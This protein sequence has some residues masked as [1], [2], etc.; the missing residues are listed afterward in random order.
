VLVV[1]TD[2]PYPPFEFGNPPY[3]GFEVDVVN[4]VARRLGTR[5][6]FE[7]ASFDTI[8]T[9]LAKR[10]FDLVAA[11]TTVSSERHAGTE[12]STPY[13]D[14][15][16]AVV[17]KRGSRIDTEDDLSGKVVGVQLATTG[18]RI[19]KD[20]T[21]ARAIRSFELIDDAFNAL[22]AGQ[23]DAIV[24]DFV[25]SSYA[26]R[27]RP[28]LRV[29]DSLATG[30]QYGIALA[31]GSSLKPKVDGAIARIRE[32]GTYARIYRKWFRSDPP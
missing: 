20:R 31:A 28:E 17:V 5:T 6:R 3:R 15:D 16:Q 7:D 19:A 2:V 9:D 25:V 14:A 1:G 32:D 22:E 13:G 24:N 23:V 29:V 12:Y 21:N 8:F 10:K 4:A 11:G 30:E 18:A 27:A 26:L